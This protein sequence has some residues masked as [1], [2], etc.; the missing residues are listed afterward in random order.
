MRCLQ[1][2][3]TLCSCVACMLAASGSCMPSHNAD[4]TLTTQWV[5]QIN[6][7]S[8]RCLFLS[9]LP[10]AS[11]AADACL[12]WSV[13]LSDT[14]CTHRGSLVGQH[15]HYQGL[16]GIRQSLKDALLTLLHGHLKLN[17]LLALHCGTSPAPRCRQ[18]SRL[19]CF[20]CCGPASHVSL[21]LGTGWG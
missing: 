19:H 14:V 1:P 7:V 6:K 16:L 20:S 12:S 21:A 5:M 10:I 9:L 17:S 15:C 3:T 4:D 8:L 18:D 13:L 11:Q 2:C